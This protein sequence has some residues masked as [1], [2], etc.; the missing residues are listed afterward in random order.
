MLPPKLAALYGEMEEVRAETLSALSGLTEEEFS[1][2]VGGEWSAA[3]ILHHLLLGKP[4][5]DAN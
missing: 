5:S 4:D 2:R 1:R 3:Q